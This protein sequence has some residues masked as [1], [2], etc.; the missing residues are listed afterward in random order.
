MAKTITFRELSNILNDEVRRSRFCDDFVM[1]I[2]P[3]IARKILCEFNGENRDIKRNNLKTISYNLAN[4]LWDNEI[5]NSI[6]FDKN[7]TLFQ[8]QHRLTALSKIQDENTNIRV[9]IGI[10]ANRS[11]Y[12]DTG[13]TRKVGDNI[14]ISGILQKE[15][16]EYFNNKIESAL[17]LLHKF[18]YTESANRTAEKF[19][20]FK[21]VANNHM[22]V[23]KGFQ[24]PFNPCTVKN[25]SNAAVLA[26][27]LNLYA[28]REIDNAD[29]E[30]ICYIMKDGMPESAADAPIIHLRNKLLETPLDA[31]GNRNMIFRYTH[32]C[33][34]HWKANKTTKPRI[35]ADMPNVFDFANTPRALRVITRNGERRFA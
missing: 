12:V 7:G 20:Y 34:R 25:T 26:A 32:A 13:A 33:V 11:I 3:S 4:G 14:R 31:G 6:M 22:N 16:K 17:N 9:R 1:F 23:I 18:Y 8:G 24:T 2:T 30:R 19:E 28:L 27:L 35:Q 21:S 5:C 10:G 15:D 29:I